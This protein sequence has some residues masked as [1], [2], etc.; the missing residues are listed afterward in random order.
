M[1]HFYCQ[2]LTGDENFSI[3]EW[4]QVYDSI[5]DAGLSEAEENRILFGDEEGCKEQCF[6][7]MAIVGQRRLKTKL[8]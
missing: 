1:C 2:K 3:E 5:K 6:A 8:L 7:C 4:N